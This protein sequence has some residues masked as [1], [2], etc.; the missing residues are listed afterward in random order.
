MNLNFKIAPTIINGE[1]GVDQ[2][3]PTLSSKRCMLVTTENTGPLAS[4][5]DLVKTKLINQGIEVTHFDQVV[6][7]PTTEIV[8][9]GI[10]KA[11][12]DRVDTIVAIG[13]G[14][15]IDVA[16]C[17]RLLAGNQS[18]DWDHLF[19]T[20]SDPF[21]TY[22]PLATTRINLIAIPTTIGTGSEVTQAAVITHNG[23]KSTIFHQNNFADYAILDT[24][25]VITLPN[26]LAAMTAFDAFTHAF[27]SY[28]STNS[29]S[30]SRACSLQ[31][32]ELIKNNLKTA[33]ATKDTNLYQELL[34]AQT[35][36]GISLANA[37][38]NLPHPLSEVIGSYTK[39]P[40]GQSLAVIFPQFINHTHTAYTAQ[41]ATIARIL[42]PSLQTQS[43]LIAS[44]QLANI[45]TNY[46]NDIGLNTS[47]NSYDI[48]DETKN[49]ILN[50]DLW[51]HLP[52]ANEETIQNILC[53]S[54]NG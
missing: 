44:S 33:L 17:I 29:T 20:C 34:S 39:L 22:Q 13:G 6:P 12:S 42:D 52:F 51:K 38:A 5:Y 18:I 21:A 48:D 24:Q 50:C 45:V 16:K 14:S 11:N 28:I 4:L 15:S 3:L 49:N 8:M 40:H 2:L 23:M 9:A 43:D 53:D 46:A 10:K 25:F 47:L 31:A 19:A 36:A 35:L 32:I 1:D 37:G 41:Y 30:L 26:T 27:E 54:F 7:N